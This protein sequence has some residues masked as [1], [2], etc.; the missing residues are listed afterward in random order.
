MFRLYHERPT[1][2][3]LIGTMVCKQ[4]PLMN[5]LRFRD[6]RELWW[7]ISRFRGTDSESARSTVLPGRRAQNVCSGMRWNT[8]QG[9]IFIT[10][11]VT[12]D[13]NRH[14]AAS[15]R[16]CSTR[17]INVLADPRTRA[18]EMRTVKNWLAERAGP[19]VCPLSSRVHHHLKQVFFQADSVPSAR[20]PPLG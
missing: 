8:V 1:P 9:E 16:N 20:P 6:H 11:H 15:R 5:A 2:E 17:W 12:A 18:D 19:E 14:R 10:R 3:I 7:P 4:I 13:R